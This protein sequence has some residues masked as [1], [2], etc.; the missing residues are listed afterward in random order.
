MES[1]MFVVLP[2]LGSVLLAYGIF[3][4]VF[5]LRTTQR[6]RLLDRLTESGSGKD[7]DSRRGKDSLLRKR[8]SEEQAKKGL[9]SFVSKLSVVPKLQQVL[10]QANVDWSASRTL[11]NLSGIAALV[12]FGGVALG[13]NPLICLGVAGSLFAL[14]IMVLMFMRK[15][16][17]KRL[18]EQLPDVFELLS[19]AL[20]AGHSLASGIH[21]IS[22]QMPDPAG[23]EFGRVFYEQNLGIKIEE[24]FTNMA[25][26]M[27]Q[28]DVR[29]FVTAVLIQRTTGGD[30][31]EIL[32]KIGMVIRDRIKLFGT[33]A[34]LTAEG[35]LSGWVL[36]ALPVLVF[37]IE[38]GINPDYAGM[39]LHDP[40]GKIMLYTAIG[41]C[42]MGMAM[43]KKIV[44]IKV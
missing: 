17:M 19:Q 1:I 42:V 4:V 33:V 41:M 23:T 22:E 24:A 16:R 37:F 5:D 29:F 31:A 6:K 26:R 2:V 40:Q 7:T 13:Q 27:D 9:D 11:V 3:Q 34:A 21:L 12:G 18:V 8:I 14:P 36:I 38:L 10:D 35:R 28:M 30:L 20:R 39:L 43:I 32:D 25:N 15:R 44:D